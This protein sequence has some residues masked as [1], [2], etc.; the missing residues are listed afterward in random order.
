MC[1]LND[2]DNDNIADDVSGGVNYI[3]YT[4]YKFKLIKYSKNILHTLSTDSAVF[5][6]N[7]Q[8]TQCV[9]YIICLMDRQ[10]EF[11]SPAHSDRKQF[12]TDRHTIGSKTKNLF[13]KCDYHISI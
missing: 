8:F 4:L 3:L 6:L 12:I 2:D 10:T 1:V 9:V 5:K 13:G 11:P 7:I